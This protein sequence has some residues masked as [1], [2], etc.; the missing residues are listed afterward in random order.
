MGKRTKLLGFR[1][2]G[3]GSD[4]GED[5][6]RGRGQFAVPGSGAIIKDLPAIEA[7]KPPARFVHNEV[8]GG[9]VMPAWNG[10]LDETTIKALTVYVHSLGGGQ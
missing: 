5:R 2:Y 6:H 3:C 7:R 9:N 1:A 4:F 8:G 10:R